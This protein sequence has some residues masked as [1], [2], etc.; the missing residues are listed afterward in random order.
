MKF[1]C[2]RS[3]SRQIRTKPKSFARHPSV[4]RACATVRLAPPFTITPYPT[5][6]TEAAVELHAT[7]RLHDDVAT[8]WN[9]CDSDGESPSRRAAD[10]DHS[11]RNRCSKSARK[12]ATWLAGGYNQI[13]TYFDLRSCSKGRDQPQP[14][15]QHQPQEPKQKGRI[16]APNH[17]VSFI[18]IDWVYKSARPPRNAPKEKRGRTPHARGRLKEKCGRWMVRGA[19]PHETLLICWA[20]VQT[21][22][23]RPVPRMHCFLYFD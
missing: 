15:W 7:R 14:T 17:N 12:C 16:I 11:N 22:M 5:T 23:D 4:A 6:Q 21:T 18:N 13:P 19:L 2:N 20:K 3:C 8:T 10:R 9:C 1:A